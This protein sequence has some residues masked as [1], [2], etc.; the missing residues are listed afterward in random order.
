MCTSHRRVRRTPP[1]IQMQ[2]YK[3][4]LFQRPIY[5]SAP[6][7]VTGPRIETL[8][9]IHRLIGKTPEPVQF[10]RKPKVK[11]IEIRPQINLVGALDEVRMSYKIVDGEVKVSLHSHWQ[12]LHDDYYSKGVRPPIRVVVSA[13]RAWRCTNQEIEWVIRKHMDSKEDPKW[14]E[15]FKRMFPNDTK[16]PPKKKALKAVIKNK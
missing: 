1:K 15:D 16:A 13:M 2:K 4:P 6:F 9:L 10:A 3:A 11:P 8:D 12:K 5:Q 14:D 7:A